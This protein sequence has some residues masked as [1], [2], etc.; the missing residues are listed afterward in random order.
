[1]GIV[2]GG[3]QGANSYDLLE[4]GQ[5][6]RFSYTDHQTVMQMRPYINLM[7]DTIIHEAKK[8][9]LKMG[10]EVGQIENEN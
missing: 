2:S 1:M 4:K 5:K 3:N 6:I 7:K 8:R 9:K 10:G